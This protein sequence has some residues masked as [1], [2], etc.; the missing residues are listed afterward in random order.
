M[1]ADIPGLL[2]RIRPRR[3]IDANSAVLLPY[4]PDGTMDLAGF[5]R[6]LARTQTAGIVPAVNMDTGFGPQ[7]TVTERSLLIRETRDAL[8]AGVPFIAGAQ[9]FH[10]P[11]DPLAAYRASVAEIVGAGG[12][13]IVFQSPLFAGKT[14][15]DLETLYRDI[16][17]DAPTA[18]AFELGPQFAPFGRI[19]DADDF[20]RLLAIPNLTG[21]KHSSLSRLTEL[22]R[23]DR[24][25]RER[26]AFRVYTGNDL[27]IDMV[28]Y[29]SEY[30]LGLS[31]FDPEAFAL[32]DRWWFA[33]DPRF[34]ELNDALQALGMVA[35]RDPVPAYKHSA[36]VYLDLTGAL[37]GALPHPAC[38][39]RPAWEA[40]LL[41]PLAALIDAAKRR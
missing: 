17:G 22:E 37:P 20:R 25:A 13:P 2:G 15:A 11:G 3:R 12:I 21:A 4:R 41:R 28:M 10:A 30:L 29:G 34:F 27:A 31:T 24:V 39:R 16:I 36:A 7:L 26:P 5:R 14:G 19:Y 38:P 23:L 6:H 18:V 9:P 8:G 32:R 1:N 40:D 33:G 35:F